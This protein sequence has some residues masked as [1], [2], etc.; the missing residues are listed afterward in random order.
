ML[1]R[2]LVLLLAVELAALENAALW[3]AI[4]GAKAWKPA[5][6]SKRVSTPPAR[7][8]GAS[9][10]ATCAARQCSPSLGSDAPAGAAA[11][12]R[13]ES[14]PI[15]SGDSSE[16]SEAAG[17][18]CI[19]DDAIAWTS[20]R[21]GRV[22]SG[23]VDRSTFLWSRR[24]SRLSSKSES[25]GSV[26]ASTRPAALS[27]CGVHRVNWAS[28]L[29][30]FGSGFTAKPA[31]SELA[32]K[33]PVSTRRPFS[34][35]RSHAGRGSAPFPQSFAHATTHLRCPSSPKPQSK[36]TSSTLFST[37]R[38]LPFLLVA[39]ILSCHRRKP[40]EERRDSQN[41]CEKRRRSDDCAPKCSPRVRTPQD[42]G[43]A[44][45][46]FGSSCAGVSTVLQKK[47]TDSA[48]QNNALC[49]SAPNEV[50]YE[51]TPCSNRALQNGTSRNTEL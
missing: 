49:G 8:L 45:P 10:A 25:V 37:L 6:A 16:Y 1:T 33:W 7:W 36:T 4:D 3:V 23:Q 39:F 20:G 11:D 21:S 34:H 43:E 35:T 14:L 2:T 29:L 30:W 48:L 31:E 26:V 12:G 40:H 47:P 15:G 9:S 42:G 32:E 19:W 24:L 28:P 22:G 13:A 5:R 50:L 18:A 17:C 27:E 41:G 38:A 51:T 44:T 46:R